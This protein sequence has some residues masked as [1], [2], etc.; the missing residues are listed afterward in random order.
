MAAGAG[1]IAAAVLAA[2]ACLVSALVPSATAAG[3]SDKT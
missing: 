1:A 2:G 3:S